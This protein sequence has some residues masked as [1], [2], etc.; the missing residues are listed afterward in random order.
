LCF[1]FQV[2]ICD[3]CHAIKDS[4]AQRT[5]AVMPVLQRANRAILISGTPALNRAAE[6]YN[7]LYCLLSKDS[8]IIAIIS[9]HFRLGRLVNKWVGAKN[10]EELYNLLT[11]TI[12]IRRLKK[13]V[14]KELPE[15]N[16]IKVP[17]DITDGKSQKVLAEVQQAQKTMRELSRESLMNG[18]GRQRSQGFL[19]IW[20]KTGEA[21]IGAVK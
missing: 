16:R 8:A 20:R 1:S 7:I 12:M 21:K 14:L 3:E 5:K 10:K 18:D 19:E 2:V 4:K 15:K 6:L 9:N 11:N 13:D 17:L